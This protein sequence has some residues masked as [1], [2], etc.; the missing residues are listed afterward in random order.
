MP[1]VSVALPDIEQTVGRPSVY[2]VINQVKQIL[3]IP[4][5]PEVIYAGKRGTPS[6]SGSTTDGLNQA[7][8][9]KFVNDNLLIIEVEESYDTA[10]VQEIHSHDYDNRPVFL[11]SKLDLSLRPIYLPSNVTISFN[12]RHTS[13]T[14]VRQWMATIVKNVSRGRDTHIHDI[15]YKYPI[16]HE[17]LDFL[18]E[19]IHFLRENIDG[20]GEDFTTYF[21]NHR[22]ARLTVIT[23]Q[24]G[25]QPYLAVCEKQSQIIGRLDFTVSPEKP[26]F[27]KEQGYWETRFNYSY[28]YW[29]PDAMF[30]HYPVA[31]HN[32]FLPEKYLIHLEEVPDPRMNRIAMNYSYEALENFSLDAKEAIV[33][34]PYPYV[35]IPGFDDFK[36]DYPKHTASI[37]V[38][39]CFL[40]E[41]RQTLLNLTDLGDYEIDEDI[42]D[43]LKKEYSYLTKMYFSVFNVTLYINGRLQPGDAIEVLPDLTVRSKKPLSYRDE[44]HVRF[45][46]T[47]EITQPLYQAL[48]RMTEHPKAFVKVLSAMNELL[49]IDPDFNTLK[50]R[51]RIEEWMV[52]E[53]YRILTGL[54]FGNF[55]SSN[56]NLETLIGNQ[57]LCRDLRFLGN[58]DSTVIK[59]YLATKW[60]RPVTA[61]N[62]AIIAKPRR[63]L[64][65]A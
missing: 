40:E 44:H 37:F 45:A 35:R 30:I 8:E 32:Q 28:M 51:S 50:D 52:K 57:S 7:K 48:K 2:Q 1:S 25:K 58:I 11:D 10:A 64:E 53:I 23:N 13:E 47:P 17:F 15:E 3:E 49:A 39:R 56:T 29:R 36:Q 16:A 60:R 14:E 4:G 21:N 31:V 61:M 59:N 38:C 24:A 6:I 22:S 33:R 12:Y 27:N 42:I 43:F 63:V 26:E 41:D 19:D 55:H 54:A 9:A 46:G 62:A 34:R 18:L 65:E 20:Y 5:N